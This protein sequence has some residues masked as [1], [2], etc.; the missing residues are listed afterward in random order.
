MNNEPHQNGC[1]CKIKTENGV[2]KMAVYLE[3]N[4]HVTVIT[5]CV[6]GR[7]HR[8]GAMCECVS[9]HSHGQTV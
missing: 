9:E 8:I 5:S 6:S 7:G 1:H 2:F 3:V 4:V